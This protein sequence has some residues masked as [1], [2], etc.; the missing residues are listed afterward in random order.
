MFIENGFNDDIEYKG[1]L[2]RRVT[3]E[4]N[5][6]MIKGSSDA[7]T[8]NLVEEKDIDLLGL[9]Y[10]TYVYEKS[11]KDENFIT[12][13][14]L[15]NFI[16]AK[17]I[18][19]CLVALTRDGLLIYKK[20]NLF[21]ENQKEYEERSSIVDDFL[22]KDIG[23]YETAL[24]SRKRTQELES[25]MFEKKE[26]NTT[27]FDEIREIICKING[28]DNT[29]YDPKWE[30]TLKDA[31]KMK[32]SISTGQ[33][34]DIR[35][36]VETL[37]FYLKKMPEELKNMSYITFIHYIKLMGDFEEYKLNRSAE[38][39]GTQFKASINHWISHYK[40]MGK[41]DDVMT[42]KDVSKDVN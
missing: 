39:Q 16:F 4:D 22:E 1:I 9:P 30:A 33:G 32:E 41:Y 7:L 40:P 36:L 19:D 8:L 17:S 31:Q 26:F 37:A 27:E 42:T 25:I 23:D 28:F 35:D 38:L 2:I 14:Q 5:F 10:L 34:L 13:W 21:K 11:Q 15:L 3:L 20:T 29:Q 24:L 12:Y 6:Y 18:K